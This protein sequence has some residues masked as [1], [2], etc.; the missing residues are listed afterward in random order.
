MADVERQGDVL[1]IRRRAG[2]CRRLGRAGDAAPLIT[3]R[4]HDQC[5]STIDAMADR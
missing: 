2:R 3:I 5:N 1:G 4:S